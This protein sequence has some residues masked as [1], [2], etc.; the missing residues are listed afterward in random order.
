MDEL[1]GQWQNLSLTEKEVQ[2]IELEPDD[3]E[4]GSILVAQFLTLR[5][6]NIESVL[7]ALK[8]LWRPGMQLTARDMGKNRVIFVFKNEAD[9]E[10]VMA[11]G[12]WSFDKHLIILSRL[13]DT[14]PFAQACFDFMSFW[15]QIHDLP[16]KMM[17]KAACENIGKTLGSLEH[18][19]ALDE[20]RSKGNFI[21][22]RVNIDIRQ[23]LCRGR[24]ISLDCK[25]DHWILF[26]YE[27]L[28]N[29]CYWCGLISQGEKDCEIW[30]KAHG[31]LLP[32]SQQYGAWMRGEPERF[33]RQA[34][35][36]PKTQWTQCHSDGGE[37]VR[38]AAENRAK[39][40]PSPSRD[41]VSGSKYFSHQTPKLPERDL[42]HSLKESQ[43]VDLATQGNACM[44]QG[45]NDMSE[46]YLV[47]V[48]DKPT[49]SNPKI[50]GVQ[51][52]RVDKKSAISSPN[53][54]KIM[55]STWK[56]VGGKTR[57]TLHD[58]PIVTITGSK[59][60]NDAIMVDANDWIEGKRV[61]SDIVT[62]NSDGIIPA[63]AAT[64]P[65]RAP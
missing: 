46:L 27:H 10:R 48:R 42:A 62:S 55:G 61:R 58:V 35:K 13:D 28:T 24:K 57:S 56:R 26:K 14:I 21:R 38:R 47:G 41:S 54:N 1:T 49:Y 59:R 37:A 6:I 50:G 16:V 20:G 45:T 31:S 44:K 33:G 40:I 9:A 60:S 63:D 51:N 2:R 5:I 7:R 39:T 22:V 19:E 15:V 30:L 64:Q 29:F 32:E 8:P 18:V 11:N 17:K 65:R 52:E 3:E 53:R 12:P 36:P 25:V 4:G 43:T 23:P 34:P